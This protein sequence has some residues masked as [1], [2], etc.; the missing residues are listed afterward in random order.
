MRRN[1]NIFYTTNA[2]HFVLYSAYIDY[3]LHV[4]WYASY[5]VY[6]IGACMHAL[7]N[8]LAIQYI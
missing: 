1:H 6:I 3:N 2:A 5:A 7:N 4:G 8:A